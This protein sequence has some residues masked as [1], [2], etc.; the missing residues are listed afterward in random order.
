M[1]AKRSGQVVSTDL[2]YVPS[3][4][5]ALVFQCFDAE[6]H[7]NS[8]ASARELEEMGA[9]NAAPHMQLTDLKKLAPY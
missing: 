3:D 4:H 8:M 9:R 7:G 5:D 6:R 1:K 2:C